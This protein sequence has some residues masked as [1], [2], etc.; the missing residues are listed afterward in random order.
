MRLAA[1]HHYVGKLVS[2]VISYEMVMLNEF[3]R[4]LA[5]GAVL[6]SSGSGSVSL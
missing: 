5:L 2:V 1:R 6:V 3:D 4:L